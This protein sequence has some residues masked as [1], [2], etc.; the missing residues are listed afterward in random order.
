MMLEIQQTRGH[1]VVLDVDEEFCE[2]VVSACELR[3]EWFE[4]YGDNAVGNRL[5]AIATIWMVGRR[6][7]RVHTRVAWLALA[8]DACEWYA[9]M[10]QRTREGELAYRAKDACRQL[11]SVIREHR[12]M[13]GLDILHTA[14]Q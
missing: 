11:K 14:E 6:H 5:D 7:G 3:G 13:N 12:R 10:L 4:S 2:T 9:D 8:A 1:H